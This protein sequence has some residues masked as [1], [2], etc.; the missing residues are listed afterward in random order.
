MQSI[1][2]FSDI[3]TM[4]SNSLLN[5]SHALLM[6]LYKRDCRRQFTPSDHWLIK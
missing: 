3:K 2:L 1:A 4:N 5:S 6:L